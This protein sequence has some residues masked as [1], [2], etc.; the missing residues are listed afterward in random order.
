MSTNRLDQIVTKSGDQ[1]TTSLGDGQR[2]S[3]SHL[4]IQ[5]LGSTDE[6]NAAIGLLISAFLPSTLDS[7]FRK[8]LQ[9]IQ[10]TLFDAGAEICIPGYTT[11]TEEHIQR[12]ENYIAIYLEDLPA[13]KEFIL[14]GGT[15]AAAQAHVCRTI[16]RRAERDLVA[17]NETEPVNDTCLQLLNRLSD[18]FFV[19]SRALNQAEG[20]TDVFWQKGY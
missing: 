18:Y 14:P 6:L 10:H 2:I 19:L 17:L 7:K 3:K 20:Q 13:L 1:G 8:E 12:I 11:L 4:R 15:A 16:A 9:A 5:S